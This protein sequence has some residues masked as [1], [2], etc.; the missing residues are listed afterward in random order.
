[1]H[2]QRKLNSA[3]SDWV[4]REKKSFQEE[5]DKN[6]DGYLDKQEVADWIV[7]SEV[8][9]SLEE[10]KHLIEVTISYRPAVL[11]FYFHIYFCV[12]V[13]KVYTGNLNSKFGIN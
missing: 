5:K 1:M 13:D 12:L 8:N 3:Y 2:T 4:E 10:A 9:Y 6:N 11:A 7:P